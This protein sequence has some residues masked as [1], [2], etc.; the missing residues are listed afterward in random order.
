MWSV[1]VKFIVVTVGP[2]CHFQMADDFFNSNSPFTNWSILTES[3]F[4]LSPASAS[5]TWD[6]PTSTTAP[7][8][9]PQTLPFGCW[10]EWSCT[11]V[12]Q[13]SETSECSK[14]DV[15]SKQ[16]KQNPSDQQYL[17]WSELFRTNIICLL[18]TWE[19]TTLWQY[20]PIA[21]MAVQR[22]TT[23]FKQCDLRN[24]AD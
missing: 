14:V 16:P 18:V 13:A 15:H 6:T 23:Q 19:L 22:T 21:T 4:S 1:M 9:Y 8:L 12:F 5:S 2:Q 3:Y 7:S 11:Q 17:I 10:L 20:T 24:M